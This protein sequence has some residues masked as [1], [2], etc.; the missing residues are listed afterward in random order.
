[1]KSPTPKKPKKTDLTFIDALGEMMAGKSVTKREWDNKEI[2]G[3]LK[4]GYLMLHKEDD[5]YYFWT[6]NDG[7][8]Y[9]DDYYV[10]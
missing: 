6:L 5:Q 10:L 2:H 8:L 7:D 3:I 4:D 9:G 1:M